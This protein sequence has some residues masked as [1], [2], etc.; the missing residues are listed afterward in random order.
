MESMHE[1]A[2]LVPSEGSHEE[3]E[4]MAV[5]LGDGLPQWGYRVELNSQ[6]GTRE[7]IS[8]LNEAL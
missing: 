7:E 2:F 1:L 3:P 5:Y 6:F 4:D 8:D